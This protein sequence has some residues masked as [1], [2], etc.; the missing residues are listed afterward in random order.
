MI[1]GNVKVIT[2]DQSGQLGQILKDIA[3][4]EVYVGI[5]EEGAARPDN[6][7]MNNASLAYLHTHGARSVSM[8]KD[9]KPELDKG[10]PY[11]K[12]HQMYLASHGSPLWAI[13]PRPI[14]EPA[15]E[16]EDNKEAISDEL[17]QAAVDVMDGNA[18]QA[19]QHL[20]LAGQLGENAARD[21]FEDPRNDWPPNA[22]ATIEAKGSD[23][24]LI[25]TGELRKSIT[26]VVKES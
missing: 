16:A 7:P 13:P 14:I 5:P 1:S 19:R 4:L 22:P 12:A 17:K 9:M 11:S 24:P 8:I 23:M 18:V 15:I 21:W 3:A 2:K 10:T 6:S 20:D 25:D 26:H